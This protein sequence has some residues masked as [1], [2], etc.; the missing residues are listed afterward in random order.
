MAQLVLC[1]S[2]NSAVFFLTA[3]CHLMGILVFELS[4]LLLVPC[5]IIFIIIPNI[6]KSSPILSK[7]YR[8]RLVCHRHGMFPKHGFILGCCNKSCQGREDH[9]GNRTGNGENKIKMCFRF[10]N[11]SKMNRKLFSGLENKLKMFFGS[12]IIPKK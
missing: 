6:T 1:S 2:Q 11:N 5:I 8:M 4:R 9:C 3:R 7:P 12:K 10:E